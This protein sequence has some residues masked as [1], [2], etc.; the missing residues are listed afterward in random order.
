MIAKSSVYQNI[1]VFGY[2]KSGKMLYD[3]IKRVNIYA[4]CIFCDNDS[5]KYADTP[6]EII[7]PETAIERVKSKEI[8]TNAS[9]IINVAQIASLN[10]FLH[11]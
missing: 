3:S 10:S 1:C 5:N 4:N 2:G 9:N 11:L 7:S 8:R 6:F